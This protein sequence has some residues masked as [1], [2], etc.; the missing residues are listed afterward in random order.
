MDI[1]SKPF[2]EEEIKQAIDSMLD[3][4]ALGLNGFGSVFFKKILE[5]D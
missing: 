3:D 1:L 2:E 4:S 5:S